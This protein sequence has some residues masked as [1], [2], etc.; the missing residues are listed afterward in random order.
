MASPPREA[1]LTDA[2]LDAIA[3]EM[4]A[5]QDAA[6]PIEPFTERYPGFGVEAAYAAAHRLHEMRMAEGARPVGRKIGFTNAAMWA[7]HGVHDPIWAPVYDTTVALLEG[8]R[9]TCD[10]GRLSEPR[11]EPE[12]VLHFRSAPALGGGP[13]GV[14]ESIDWVAHGIEVVQSHFTGW[15]FAAPDTVV[16]GGLHARLFVGPRVPVEEIAVSPARAL[17]DFTL[18]LSRDGRPV[19]AGR[20][21]DVL[22]SPLAAIVHL[23]ALLERQPF[24]K[25]LAAGELVTTGTITPAH[26]VRPGERWRTALQGISLPGLEIGFVA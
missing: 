18:D 10:L 6:R 23:V 11:I 8:T 1:T 26:P 22:G 20:G 13:D 3:R 16:D 7:L 14:L 9:A 19:A 21:A 15:K 17:E 24:A 25:S 12:I 4:K 5:A 2:D